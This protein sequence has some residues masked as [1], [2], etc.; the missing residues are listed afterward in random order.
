MSLASVWKYLCDAVSRVRG[1]SLLI[2]MSS[3][4]GCRR[5]LRRTA[6]GDG[7]DFKGDERQAM[8]LNAGHTRRRRGMGCERIV[9]RRSS[10]RPYERRPGGLHRRLQYYVSAYWR[11]SSSAFVWRKP[12]DWIDRWPRIE[13][14]GATIMLEEQSSPT[15]VGTDAKGQTASGARSRQW[16]PSAVSGWR[17]ESFSVISEQHGCRAHLSPLRSYT[18]GA[19]VVEGVGGERRR[20][21]RTVLKESVALATWPFSAFRIQFH[22]FH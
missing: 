5:G 2:V 8:T 14:P 1:L 20:S 4:I 3:V 10:F 17:R 16:L 21:A 15:G 12:T 7:D 13:R 19:D 11:E 18:N 6:A 22:R 9:A